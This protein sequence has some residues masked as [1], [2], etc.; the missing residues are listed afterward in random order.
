[1]RSKTSYHHIGVDGAHPRVSESQGSRPAMANPR[2]CD[3]R[4]ARSFERITKLNCMVV[5]FRS[6]ACSSECVHM[7]RQ[8]RA[9]TPPARRHN[10]NRPH[11]LRRRGCW[12]ANNRCRQSYGRHRPRIRRGRVSANRRAHQ[13]AR[14]H[15]ELVGLTGAESRFQNAPDGVVVASLGAADE[16]YARP[17]G[18]GAGD[19]RDADH[20]P[21]LLAPSCARCGE[22]ITLTRPPRAPLHAPAWD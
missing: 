3:S 20:Q 9:Q 17:S 1:M 5:N 19:A 18:S 8:R 11:V 13:I 4:T 21:A 2:L 6:R 10:R 7:A 22:K 15:V 14:C 16:H 12:R